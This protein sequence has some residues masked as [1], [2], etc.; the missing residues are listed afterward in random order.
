MRA[1]LSA[2]GVVLLH[3]AP[4]SAQSLQLDPTDP[5]A[6][7]PFESQGELPVSLD[8]IK[9]A[10]DRP[11]PANGRSRLLNLTEF[12]VVV[13]TAPTLPLF[14]DDDLSGGPVAQHAC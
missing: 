14:G 10:L 1:T 3:S 11:P 12:V 7:D 2:L 4:A 8:R 6:V 9:R 5:T 13:G